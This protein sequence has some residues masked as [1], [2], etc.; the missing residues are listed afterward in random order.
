MAPVK[1]WAALLLLSVIG[2]GT[3]LGIEIALRGLTPIW[4]AAIRIS[5][6][7]IVMLVIWRRMGGRLFERPLGPRTGTMLL[8]ISLLSTVVPF[9]LISWGQQFVTSGFASV[10]LASTA[11][12]VSPLAYFFVPGEDMGVRRAAGMVLGFSG[13]VILINPSGAVGPTLVGSLAGKL[14]CLSAAACYATSSII[15]R[16]LPEVNPIGLVAVMLSI[17]ATL[18]VPA[19]FVISGP[20]GQPG[21]QALTAVVLL[22]LLSTGGSNMLGVLIIRSA[23][24]TFMAYSNYLTPVFAVVFG[25]V[26]LDEIVTRQMLWGF[27]LVAAGLAMAQSHNRAARAANRSAELPAEG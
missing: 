13:V 23:G 2:G 24:P 4:V 15:V 9:S 3:F 22:A 17:G 27:A 8:A 25:A 6:A 12:I 21:A 5:L 11:L 7:A 16:R 19:A 1:N 14:A 26:I 20:P 10:A 18:I